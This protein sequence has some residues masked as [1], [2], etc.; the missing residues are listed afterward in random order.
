MIDKEFN[1]H[2][3]EKNVFVYYIYHLAVRVLN[4]Q[5]TLKVCVWYKVGVIFII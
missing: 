1:Q 5:I 4:S 3:F 2:F